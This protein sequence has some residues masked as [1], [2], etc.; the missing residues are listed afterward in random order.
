MEGWSPC[1]VKF[2][3]CDKLQQKNLT[4]STHGSPSALRPSDRHHDEV[5]VQ[6]VGRDRKTHQPGENYIPADDYRE[7]PTARVLR[8]THYVVPVVVNDRL[9]VSTDRQRV[10]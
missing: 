4:M 3:R 8:F 1:I 9:L 10:G 2:V 7:R 5:S 6:E